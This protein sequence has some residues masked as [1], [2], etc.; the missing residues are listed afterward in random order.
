MI[1]RAS[2]LNTDV[3][4][5]RFGGQ[6]EFKVTKILEMDQLQGKGRL[7]ARNILEPGHSLGWHQHTGDIEAYYIVRGE[8]TVNDNGTK[9]VVRPG[10]VVYTADGEHH[11]IDNT[12]STTLEFIALILYTSK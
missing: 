12:G 10:D 5:N 6:G 2:E 4:P 7:F 3:F 9:V 11:S 1:K 8:G